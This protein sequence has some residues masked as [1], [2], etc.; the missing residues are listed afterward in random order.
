MTTRHRGNLDN[1]NMVAI[2]SWKM[3][4]RNTYLL[5]LSAT[6]KSPP[7]YYISIALQLNFDIAAGQ[8]HSTLPIVASDRNEQ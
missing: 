8:M 4:N 5:V 2:L 1:I 6:L 3:I 7:V